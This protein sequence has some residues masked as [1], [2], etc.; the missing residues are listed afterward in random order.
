VL[1]G[2]DRLILGCD[3][4]RCTV[5]SG[6]GRRSCALKAANSA[7]LLTPFCR[8]LNASSMVAREG[9]LHL[10]APLLWT[11]VLVVELAIFCA[12]GGCRGGRDEGLGVKSGL[13]RLY[14]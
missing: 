7:E 13:E 5:R 1:G 9:R 8:F 6:R 4:K 2:R 3:G 11:S 12:L 14:R 10:P